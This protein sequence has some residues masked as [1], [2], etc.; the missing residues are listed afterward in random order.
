M[1][2]R[3]TCSVADHADKHEGARLAL[4]L[5][6]PRYDIRHLERLPLGTTYPAQV[7]RVAGMLCRDPLASHHAHTYIDYTGVGRGVMDMF[8]ETR[9]PRLHPV[10]ITAGNAITRTADGWHVAKLE[11]ISRVQALLHTGQLS[12]AKELAD[13]AT[14]MRELQDFHVIFSSAGNAQFGAREGAHDDL[15]LAAAMAIFGATRAEPVMELGLM[16][17][18]N[19]YRY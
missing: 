14:L 12:I 3:E 11:L 7:R 8:K 1:V 9:M 2:E 16:M 13:T 17:P 4:K 10:T 6:K 5:P 15:V 19:G 18:G